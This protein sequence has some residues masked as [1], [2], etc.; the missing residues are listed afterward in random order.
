MS[1]VITMAHLIILVHLI[2]GILEDGP[3]FARDHRGTFVPLELL[4][5][6]VTHLSTVTLLMTSKLLITVVHFVT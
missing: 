4:D 3:R 6:A 1:H 5:G 2:A